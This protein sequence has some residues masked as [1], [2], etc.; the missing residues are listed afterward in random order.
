MKSFLKQ[1]IKPKPGNIKNPEGEIIGYHK[2]VMYYTIGE[3]IGPRLGFDIN[4]KYKNKISK[5]LYIANKNKRTNAITIAPQDHPLLYKKSF[6]IIKINFIH[7]KSRFPLNN[8]KIRI[9]HLGELIPAKIKYKNKKYQCTLKKAIKGIAEG[10]SAVIYRKNV[11]LGG[12]EI[13]FG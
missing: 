10:Q 3:R 4:K 12:G 5:K 2:G 8:I 7:N 6:Y 9:R 11:I 1:K 13:R